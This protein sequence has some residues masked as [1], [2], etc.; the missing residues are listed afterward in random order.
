MKVFWYG[1]PAMYLV[2]I[3]A[4]A[5]ASTSQAEANAA[6]GAYTAALLRCVDQAKTLQESRACRKKVNADW[7]ITETVTKDAGYHGPE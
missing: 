5:C 6:E 1:A 4:L 3:L 2:G 7:G